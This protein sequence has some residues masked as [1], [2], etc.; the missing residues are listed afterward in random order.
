ME[1]MHCRL[2]LEPRDL[3]T[4]AAALKSQNNGVAI[5]SSALSLPALNIP[6]CIMAQ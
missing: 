2:V 3:S 6:I 5:R 1:H 4:V